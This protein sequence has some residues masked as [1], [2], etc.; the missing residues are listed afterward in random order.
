MAQEKMHTVWVRLNAVVFF[1]LTVIVCLAVITWFSTITHRG[2]PTVT[3]LKLN[4]LKSLRSHGNRD[5]AVLTFDLDADL[6]PA[7]NW[8]IKQLFVFVVAE[9]KSKT[10]PLNQVVVWDKVIERKE[11]AKIH[12]NKATVEYGLTDQ[13]TELRNTT[14][15]LRLVWDHMP[16]TGRLFMEGHSASSFKLPGRYQ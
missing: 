6:S 12:L 2:Y 13:G 8:N 16:L 7:F 11:D 3:A 9:Y 10:N 5:I 1:G 4:T 14:V 15:N